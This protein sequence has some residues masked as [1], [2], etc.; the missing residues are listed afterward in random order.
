MVYQLVDRCP[1][2]GQIHDGI[3]K[4]I[5]RRYHV[6]QD[7]SHL[8]YENVHKILMRWWAKFYLCIHSSWSGIRK[9]PQNQFLTIRICVWARH[10][11]PLRL[12]HDNA[13][14]RQRVTF[15]DGGQI[16]YKIAARVYVV[17]GWPWSP[18]MSLNLRKA[19]FSKKSKKNVFQVL[20]EFIFYF[21]KLIRVTCCIWEIQAGA[22]KDGP[23]NICLQKWTGQRFWTA[24]IGRA[25]QK[26]KYKRRATHVSGPS[27]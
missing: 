19:T 17:Y 12:K 9:W 5:L 1:K 21:G 13:D 15:L 3:Y 10:N 27:L 7:A 6:C 14:K 18:I 24:L 26:Q 16:L 2:T 22:Y 8:W 25:R 20:F 11:I 4:S 23:E